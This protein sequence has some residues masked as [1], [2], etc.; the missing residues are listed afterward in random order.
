MP[1]TS[2]SEWLDP[3]DCVPS[4]EELC[5]EY[6]LTNEDPN[7]DIVYVT[8]REEHDTEFLADIDKKHTFYPMRL[9]CI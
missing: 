6:T 4:I 5:L 7:T 3:V 2:D 9:E 8:V 1:D